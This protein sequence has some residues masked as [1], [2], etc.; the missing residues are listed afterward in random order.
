MTLW[1]AA[2]VG[3]ARHLMRVKP[4]NPALFARMSVPGPV[5]GLTLH[6]KQQLQ[7][8]RAVE[9]EV[10]ARAFRDGNLT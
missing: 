10:R 3:A 5:P 4:P 1:P 9:V 2:T 7:L 8:G 6:V